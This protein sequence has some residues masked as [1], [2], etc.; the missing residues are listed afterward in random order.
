MPKYEKDWETSIHH[1]G[2]GKHCNMAKLR[3]RGEQL[4]RRV[5]YSFVLYLLMN[6][7]SR[8]NTS[9]KRLQ[10]DDH[11]QPYWINI[12]SLW[13]IWESFC[14]LQ[15][16]IQLLLMQSL[17]WFCLNQIFMFSLSFF[18]L[19][20]LC[21]DFIWRGISYSPHLRRASSHA[22][23]G[24]ILFEGKYHVPIVHSFSGNLCFCNSVWRG[25]P[26]VSSSS[27]SLCNLHCCAHLVHFTLKRA[28]SEIGIQK[29]ERN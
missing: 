8:H 2:C 3:Y 1:V 24:M 11:F 10:F 6:F 28:A 27:L 26:I 25:I 9:M 7:F 23:F 19:G 13:K 16:L 22:I 12:I 15:R 5:F 21:F 17:L 18:F 4:L 14:F 20:S 29:S